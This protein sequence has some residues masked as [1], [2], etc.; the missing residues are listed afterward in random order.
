MD[1]EKSSIIHDAMLDKIA[2]ENPGGRFWIKA[3][4]CDVSRGWRES[5]PHEWTGDT[6]IGENALQRLNDSYDKRRAFCFKLR[7]GGRKN[8]LTSDLGQILAE[9]DADLSFLDKGLKSSKKLYNEMID[10]VSSSKESL[11]LLLPPK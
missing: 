7:I 10:K 8:V 1:F 5:M 6:D 3:D 11:L 4:W 2:K 9:L